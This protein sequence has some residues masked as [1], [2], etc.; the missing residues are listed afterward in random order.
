MITYREIID[1]HIS[2][3]LTKTQTE[4][5]LKGFIIFNAEI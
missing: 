1:G 3:N 5:A 2:S 4:F